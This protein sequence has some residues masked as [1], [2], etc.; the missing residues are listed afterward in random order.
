MGDALPMAAGGM[1][2]AG[3]FAAN[4]LAQQADFVLA[5]GTRMLDVSTCAK[6]AFQNPDVR[7]A[8]INVLG[9]DA[10]EFAAEPILADAKEGILK[11]ADSAKEVGFTADK[12]WVS[13]IDKVKR[14]WHDLA[15]PTLI[16]EDGELITQAQALKIINDAIPANSYTV[17]VAGSL[18]G[19][20]HKLWNTSD[21]KRCHLDFGYSCM[22]YEIP[23]GIGIAMAGEE[24]VFVCIG[25]GTYL[26][27]PSDLIV[28][29]REKT[30]ITVCLFVNHGYQIIRD[31]QVLTTGVGFDSEFRHRHEDGQ[32]TGEFL[33]IDFCKHASS[34]GAKVHKASTK[35]ELGNSL[36]QARSENGL[37][38]VVIEVD[39]YKMSVGTKNS[40]WDIAPP[41]VSKDP[42]AQELRR[43]Y[44]ERCD[45]IQR[46]YL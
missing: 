40:F 18:P 45:K 25:D 2:V 6:T 24:N 15:S 26:M 12:D 3:N 4:E 22:T 42:K 34:L 9:K 19:D 7:F 11:L 43:S 38:V 41:M 17:A 20:V 29:A 10:F 44:E 27:N 37:S 23:S 5:V 39:P 28:A 14:E 35:E 33:E 32:A 13:T 46:Y 8:S 31:L 1:G 16:P 30:N 36:S 21:N